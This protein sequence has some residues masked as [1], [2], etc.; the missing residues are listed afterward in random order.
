MGSRHLKACA[1]GF[2]YDNMQNNMEPAAQ[3]LENN[4]DHIEKFWNISPFREIVDT[5]SI[6]TKHS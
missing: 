5:A 2:F 4:R 3:I 6:Q 1:K